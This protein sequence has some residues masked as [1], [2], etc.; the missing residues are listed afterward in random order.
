M[1]H[2]KFNV[3]DTVDQFTDDIQVKVVDKFDNSFFRIIRWEGNINLHAEE[4]D[5]L[6]YVVEGEIEFRFEKGSRKIRAG[7][8]III[9]AGT[10]HGPKS[11]GVVLISVEPHE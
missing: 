8:G 9:K 1:A 5:E 7:E 2:Q 10:P 4:Q 11:E 3:K 6:F